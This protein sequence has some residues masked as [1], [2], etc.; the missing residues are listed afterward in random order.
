MNN[1]DKI[2]QVINKM[3]ENKAKINGVI[4]DLTPQDRQEYYFMY[5]G[6]K[7]SVARL[8]E[9]AS[10]YSLYYYPDKS[11]SLDDISR[12]NWSNYKEFMM[13]KSD[14]YKSQEA[15][16]SFADL[17]L[18]VQNKLYDVDKIFDKILES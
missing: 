7:W 6:F 2:I 9:N 8:D 3:V 12:V 13:Y 16:E 4:K 18:T 5:D 10:T 15:T 1:M 17:F 14:D 11:L